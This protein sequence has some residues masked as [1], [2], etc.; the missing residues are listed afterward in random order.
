MIK[1]VKDAKNPFSR[2]TTFGREVDINRFSNTYLI[3]YEV[4][5]MGLEKDH[6][7][8]GA[9][10]LGLAS[11][12]ILY[13][14]YSKYA[15]QF[16]KIL[17]KHSHN[18][19][20]AKNS[21]TRMFFIGG[22]L[23]LVTPLST[24]SEFHEKSTGK[25]KRLLEFQTLGH[26]PL[27]EGVC[28]KEIGQEILGKSGPSDTDACMKRVNAEQ[29][30]WTMPKIKYILGWWAGK[31]AAYD[32]SIPPKDDNDDEKNKSNN[33]YYAALIVGITAVLAVT[34]HVCYTL[35]SRRKA[36]NDEFCSSA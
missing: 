31:K 5:N 22:A 11:P 34:G 6:P 26:H 9:A 10:P 12:C 24:T 29:L 7:C 19:S 36:R 13:K 27:S 28:A 30:D 14:Y 32:K 1:F 4:F 15:K 17:E 2:Y 3:M 35:Y 20:I 18:Y 23:D 33:W 21:Q 16:K 8:Q 25:E